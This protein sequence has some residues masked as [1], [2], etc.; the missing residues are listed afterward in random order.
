M[1]SDKGATMT[2]LDKLDYLTDREV[3][4][5]AWHLL[6]EL[7]RRHM[8]DALAGLIDAG[9]IECDGDIDDPDTRFWPKGWRGN[10]RV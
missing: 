4:L 1:P 3:E 8:A 7:D 6:T 9:F 5:L 10:D 2:E